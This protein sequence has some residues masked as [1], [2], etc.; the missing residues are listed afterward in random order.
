MQ[1]LPFRN[2]H[3]LLCSAHSFLDPERSISIFVRN[4]CNFLSVTRPSRSR[5]IKLSVGKWKRISSFGSHDPEL[6]PLPAQ[7]RTVDDAF[8]VRRPVRSRFPC[9]LFVPDFTRL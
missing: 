2:R 1:I 7:V 4:K 5:Y 6:V 8:A 9:G 3:F